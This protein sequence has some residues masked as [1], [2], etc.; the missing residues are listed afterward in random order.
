MNGFFFAI[1]LLLLFFF[2]QPGPPAELVLLNAD[3]NSDGS[4]F[5]TD[6]ESGSSL[7]ALQ[8]GALDAAGNRTS[9]SQN[10]TWNVSLSFLSRFAV[11]GICFL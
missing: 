10:E 4:F 9:P 5:S 1:F 2:A 8:L 7:A 6:T 3:P 11:L